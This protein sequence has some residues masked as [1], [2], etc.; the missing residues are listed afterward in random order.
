M[1][2]IVQELRWGRGLTETDGRRDAFVHDVMQRAANEIE[3]L[4]QSVLFEQDRIAAF[5]EERERLRGLLREAYDGP[6]ALCSHGIV[7]RIADELGVTPSQ[8]DAAP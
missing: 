5:L 6:L 8:P 7:P 1:G 3:R 2:D 4:R